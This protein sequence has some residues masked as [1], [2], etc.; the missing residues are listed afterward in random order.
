MRHFFGSPFSLWKVKIALTTAHWCF[1]LSPFLQGSQSCLG[2]KFHLLLPIWLTL[3][4]CLLKT[5]LSSY[6]LMFFFSYQSTWI[7]FLSV[8]SSPRVFVHN[9]AINMGMHAS[10]WWPVFISFTYW[11]RSGIAPDRMLVLFLIFWG[12]SILF[13]STALQHWFTIAATGTS[14]AV[15]WL[16]LCLPM[17]RVHAWPLVGELR[18][19]MP[20]GQKTKA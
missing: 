20:R 1:T 7:L 2:A 3:Q 6:H 9:A 10:F 19:H 13:F 14:L 12:C 8:S 15:R 17:F 18:S 5:F 11:P 16:G 4:R